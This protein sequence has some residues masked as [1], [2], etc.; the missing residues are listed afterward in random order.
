MSHLYVL[1][2]SFHVCVFF[3]PPVVSVFSPPVVSSSSVFLLV[4]APL[5]KHHLILLLIRFTSALLFPLFLFLW[6]FLFFLQLSRFSPFICS[7]FAAPLPTLSGDFP[8]P[9][10]FLPV[11]PG[12]FFRRTNLPWLFQKLVIKLK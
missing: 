11:L 1:L 8:P 2:L 7:W 9:P 12:C 5:V 10:Q 3:L 4:Q 6:L